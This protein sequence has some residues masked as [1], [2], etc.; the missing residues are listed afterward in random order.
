MLQGRRVLSRGDALAIAAPRFSGSSNMIALG[1]I[2]RAE[3]DPDNA[4]IVLINGEAA[5]PI[6][7]QI[8]PSVLLTAPIFSCHLS[9]LH[10][11]C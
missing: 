4:G 9:S 1:S 8:Q 3:N 6:N 2:Y 11:A 7:P 10:D 5:L